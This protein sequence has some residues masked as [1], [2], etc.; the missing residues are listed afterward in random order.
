MPKL[1]I[2]IPTHNRADML[3][4]AIDSATSQSF[5]DLEVIVVDDGS[6]VPVTYGGEDPRVSVHRHERARGASAARNTGLAHARG[7]YTAFLD[8][9]DTLQPD[10]ACVMVGYF[11]ASGEAIDF[12]WPALQVFDLS[13]GK[14][15]LAQQHACLIRR[16]APSSERAYVAIS[17]TRTTGMVFRTDSIRQFGGFDETLSVSEDRELIFRMLSGGCGCGSV[18]TPLVNFF[19]HPGP[20][21]SAS[22]SLVKQARCDS[23]V[24]D[25]HADFI[26]RHPR[27]AARYLNMVARRQKN[28]GLISEYRSTL[29]RILRIKRFDVRALKRLFLST[30]LSSRR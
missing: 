28:A 20:R 12:A 6:D 17:Y 14:E 30:F 26:A 15:F 10:Y 29:I 23:L 13:T 11:D 2:I 16:D 8:D 21:L 5:T 4:K 18:D 27:L 19:I 9:D 24:A 25:R 22:S 7:L 3:K 1:S